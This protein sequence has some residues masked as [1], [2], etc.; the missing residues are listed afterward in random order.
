MIYVTGDC[1]SEFQKLGSDYFPE[2]KTLTKDD[3]VIICGDF[4]GIWWN[5]AE[6]VQRKSE[7][8]WIKWLDDK[9]FTTLF[10]DGNHENHARL[11]NYPEEEWHGGRIHRI[12]D[13][14][15]HLM[16]G[17]VFELCE[18][19]V[20][21]FGGASSHD[22]SDG[23]LDGSAPDWKRQ[24]LLFELEGRYMY[25]VKGVSWWPE[26]LPSEEEL[27]NGLDNLA[28]CGNSVDYII[29]HCAADS[30]QASISEGYASDR[31]TQYFEQLRSTVQYEKWF[32]GHYHRDCDITEKDIL[33]YHE[34]RAI[35]SGK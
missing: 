34:I 9:P 10:V 11:A 1:H 12:A 14:V 16:R 28:K 17:E 29:T 4:G 20:F 13:S 6:Y 23:I 33:L 25:R 24:A 26:E 30:V 21:A 19:R 31:L 5:S 2:G 7:D 32:F 18:K 15:F 3:Y 27:Q 35:N 22:I 8:Y